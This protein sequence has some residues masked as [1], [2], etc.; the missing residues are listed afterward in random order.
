MPQENKKPEI[1]VIVPVYNEEQGIGEVLDGL[2]K[3]LTANSAKYEI[4][5]IDDGSTDS[6]A[7]I[8]RRKQVV[9]INHPVNRGY[10]RSLLTGFSN[11]KY[12]WILLIDG[13][14]SY[15]PEEASKLI[16]HAPAFDMVIGARQGIFFWGS[17]F[18]TLLR[19]IY[20][21][22]AGFVAGEPVP[23]ANSGLRLVKKSSYENSMPFLCLGYSFTTTMTLS[24]LRAGRFV[25]YVPIKFTERTGSSKVRPIRDILRTLQI[26]TQI[27][28]YYNPLKLAAAIFIISL[29]LSLAAFIG[30]VWADKLAAAIMVVGILLW[31][32]V[33]IFLFGCILDS[34]RLNIQR[35]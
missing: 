8:A 6:T 10:G 18:K 30:L 15:P 35:K 7:E 22:I 29:I 14:G 21:T 12:E 2:H 24:F 28:I 20:L 3:V 4:L 23:D 16:K 32:A 9:V 17:L 27:I 31:F 1:S 13:D 11:S 25:K 26:M 34:I 33:V 19:W 5:V